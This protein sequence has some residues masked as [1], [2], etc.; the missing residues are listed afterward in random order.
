MLRRVVTLAVPSVLENVANS[1]IFMIDALMVARLGPAALAAVGI[2]GVV[3]WRLRSVGGALQ[4]GV[5]AVLARRW[6]EGDI[7]A[8]SRVY[9]HAMV[10]GFLSGLVCLLLYP[11]SGAL[12]RL[13]ECPPDVLEIVVPYFQIIL[14]SYPLRLVSNNLAAATRA[15]GNTRVPLVISTVISIVNVFGNYLLIFGKWG[16]PEMGLLGA[17]LATSISFLVEFLIYV[18]LGWRGTRG[19]Q[20]FDRQPIAVQPPDEEIDAPPGGAV[21]EPGAKA[22]GPVLRFSREGFRLRIPGT[23]G[24]LVRISVPTFFEEIA[25]T[26]GF[27][28]FIG[29]IAHF[30]E[31]ITAAHVAVVRIESFS[32]NVGFGISIAAAAL[33]GQALGAGRIDEARRAFA[34]CTCISMASMGLL[35]IG[36][37]LFPEWLLGWFTSGREGAMDD[38][39]VGIAVPL[40]ILAAIEQPFIGATNSLANGLRGAGMTTAP[41]LAQFLGVVVVRIG[42][43]YWLAYPLGMG[44]EGIYIATVVDWL[45]RFVVLG[46]IVL[47]GRWMHVKL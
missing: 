11:F 27:L 31:V 23:T 29:M 1:A 8:A 32:F 36:F 18:W 47:R 42:L 2:A 15:S 21:P 43:G 3:L 39:L 13:L 17:G 46:A 40:L 14:L 37:V 28:G 41:F 33:V 22:R 20:L 4:A 19:G 38:Q 10:L 34:L 7:G 9:T 24:T 5:G 25:I 26:I 16:F 12:F 45:M 6:G 30:G 35:A 44:V